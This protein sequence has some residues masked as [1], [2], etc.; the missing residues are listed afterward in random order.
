[1]AGPNGSG[2]STAAKHLLPETTRFVNADQIAQ[3]ISGQGDTPADL[4]AGRMLV[5]LMDGLESGREDFAVETTLANLKLIPR[6]QRLNGKGYET[7]LFFMWLPSPDLAVA[8]VAARVRMGGHDVPE[9]TVRRRYE[10]GLR[11]FFESYMNQVGRWRMYDNS[12]LNDPVR[13]ASGGAGREVEVL[14]PELWEKIVRSWV[15]IA[16][17]DQLVQLLEEE[18]VTD[19]TVRRAVAEAI[20]ENKARKNQ[21]A[22]WDGEK[23]VLIPAEQIPEVKS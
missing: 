11:H 20:E 21:V 23:V 13:I 14:V 16:G 9:D 7:Q 12:S 15:Q 17:K 5:E 19:E 22:A 10:R 6:L 8:R 2:K 4:R 1:M 3:E 18:L